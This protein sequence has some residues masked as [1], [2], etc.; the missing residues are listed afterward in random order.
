MSTLPPFAL[1]ADEPGAVALA[2]GIIG[3]SAQIRT[4]LWQI[5][6][7]GAMREGVIISGEDGTGRGL[8]A[9]AIHA[10]G[11]PATAPFVPVYCDQH[12]AGSLEHAL[13]GSGSSGA[14][15]V[16]HIATGSLLHRARGGTLYFRHIEDMP[17]RAQARLSHVFRDGEAVIDDETEAERGVQ[18]IDVRPMLAADTDLTLSVTDGRVRQDLYRR[19]ARVC[20]DLPPLR[21]RRDDIPALAAHFVA[22]A[23]Y[24]AGSP[25]KALSDSAIT[26]LRALPWRGNAREL[27]SVL[28]AL[29]GQVKATEIGV[30]DVLAQLLLD[31]PVGRPPSATD[32]RD[33]LRAARERF[34]R[35]YVSAV[36]A[37]CRGRIPAAAKA[38][39]I[40]RTN[41]YRKMRSLHVPPRGSSPSGNR[42]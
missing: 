13:F 34:E 30:A 6:N 2:W 26:V 35:D 17:G 10:C 27:Q 29:V 24:D 7:A 32:Y 5:E 11:G 31:T 22:Q 12:D 15:A 18:S 1:C 28:S 4:V 20:I 33:T 25:V 21:E 19:F 42:S 39:G 9:R 38:L 14:S 40:Q 36:L 23:C 37:R 8:V 41:L 3:Q 16:E